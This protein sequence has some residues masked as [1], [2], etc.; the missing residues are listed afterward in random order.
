MAIRKV[1]YS[2]ALL[3]LMVALVSGCA[4]Q[5]ASTASSAT[6]RAITVVGVGKAAGTPDVAQVSVGIETRD[7]SVQKA[8]ADNNT[9]MTEL[10]AALKGLG[11]AD[12]DIRTSNFSV[13]AERAPVFGPEGTSESGPP[14]YTVNNQVTVKL[15]DVT[16]L[17]NVLD[18]AVAAGANNIYGVTFTVEDATELEAQARGKAVDDARARAE[19]LAKLAGVSL[20]EVLSVSE[21]IGSPGPLY[22]RAVSLVAGMGTGTPIEAGELEVTMNVQVTYAIQ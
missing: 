16:Q 9:R 22:E 6:Q 21:V 1:V 4:T 15:R 18:A 11:I 5:A 12:G 3:L 20:G 8:V 7:P 10:L 2:G 17:A 14:T 19:S 13:Y